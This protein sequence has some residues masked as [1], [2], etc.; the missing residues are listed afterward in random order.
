MPVGMGLKVNVKNNIKMLARSCQSFC[1]EDKIFY[2]VS[3]LYVEI[4]DWEFVIL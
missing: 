1:S 4:K 2:M 3:T